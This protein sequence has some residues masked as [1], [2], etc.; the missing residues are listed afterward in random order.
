[1]LRPTASGSRIHM[2]HTQDTNSRGGAPGPDEPACS[3]RVV[4]ISFRKGGKRY[5]FDAGGLYLRQGTKVIAETSRGLEFGEVTMEPVEEADVTLTAPLKSSVRLATAD[6]VERARQNRDRERVAFEFAKEKIEEQGIEMKLVDVEYAF[7]ASQA[8]FFF[9][10]EGRVDFRQL[11]KELTTYL[12][13]KVQ[14]HQLGARDET[15]V[16]G[17]LG[18]C[19]R[20]L[21]CASWLRS[22]DPVGMKMAKEQSLFLNPLKFSG[23]CGK[24]MCCLR[25]EYDMYKEL[26]TDLPNVGAI[27]ETESGRGKVAAVN[28]LQGLV[29]VDLEVGASATLRAREIRVV[30]DRKKGPAEDGE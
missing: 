27:V 25:Y 21:C 3:R 18:V 1:M 10:A 15:K 16:F 6:D 9:V 29:T 28:V 5:F 24:L 19:G 7:D 20:V 13:R 11:V 8:T 12:G 14:M 4:G 26:R 17:G 2:S 23:V 30:R 22:F